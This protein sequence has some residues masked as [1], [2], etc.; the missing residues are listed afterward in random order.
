MALLMEELKLP[1]TVSRFVTL[2]MISRVAL[3]LVT[4]PPPIFRGLPPSTNAPALLLKV[5]ELMFQA[6]STFGER[7]VVPAKTI[8]AVPSFA[9]ATAPDQFAAVL[10]LAST[11]P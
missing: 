8:V 2:L 6:A 5:S 9:G 1:L 4:P 10:Q 11:P 7:S 3:L